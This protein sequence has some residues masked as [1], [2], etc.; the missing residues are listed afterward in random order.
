MKQLLAVF[1]V[2]SR[3]LMLARLTGPAVTGPE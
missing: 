1:L 3:L 2:P